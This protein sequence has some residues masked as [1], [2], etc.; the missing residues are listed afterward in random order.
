MHNA[1]NDMKKKKKIK[2][3]W[4][5]HGRLRPAPEASWIESSLNDIQETDFK[6]N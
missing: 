5:S 2:A 6:K 3:K 4:I 1:K